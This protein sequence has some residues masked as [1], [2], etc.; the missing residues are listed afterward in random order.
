[1]KTIQKLAQEAL[2]VQDA[3]NLTGVA[4]GM[5]KVLCELMVHVRGTDDV[6]THP[7]SRLWAD[8]VAS[9]AGNEQGSLYKEYCEVTRLANGLSREP[10]DVADGHNL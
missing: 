2:D 7:I 9:L 6:N 4:L 10:E 3:C 1:M 8:K 5:H